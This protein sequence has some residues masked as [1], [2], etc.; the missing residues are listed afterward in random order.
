ME[1]ICVRVQSFFD[2]FHFSKLSRDIK[3]KI[4]YQKFCNGPKSGP[5]MENFKTK[6]VGAEC[7]CEERVRKRIKR[8]NGRRGGHS[9][10]IG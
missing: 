3:K 4:R 1:R 7:V 5:W 6:A 9:A 10:G 2:I 8:Y